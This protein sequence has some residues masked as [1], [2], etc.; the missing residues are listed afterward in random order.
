M[1]IPDNAPDIVRQTTNPISTQ[2]A[3]VAQQSRGIVRGTARQQ[4]KPSSTRKRTVQH[5]TARNAVVGTRSNPTFERTKAAISPMQKSVVSQSDL[6]GMSPSPA[7]L[8]RI[9]GINQAYRSRDPKG[10]KGQPLREYRRELARQCVSRGPKNA[11]GTAN[12]R[13]ATDANIAGRMMA[14]GFT[15]RQTAYAISKGSPHVANMKSA[16]ERVNH[17]RQSVVTAFQNPQ[18]KAA[19]DTVAKNKV[20]NKIPA[21]DRRLQKMG[22][23][24]QTP[25]QPYGRSVVTQKSVQAMTSASRQKTHALGKGSQGIVRA[26]RPRR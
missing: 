4:T 17:G 14:A 15:D 24:T 20:A 12:K 13:Q 8:K 26:T 1:A 11:I 25:K 6:G 16:R 7:L 3:K 2:N 5:S 18:V 9:K 19:I 23:H 10:Y 22:V 21:Y